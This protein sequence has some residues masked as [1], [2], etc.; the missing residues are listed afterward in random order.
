[1]MIAYLRGGLSDSEKLK[2]EEQMKDDPL[3]VE[4]M[5]ELDMYL[6]SG[7]SETDAI[8]RRNKLKKNFSSSRQNNIFENKPFIYSAAASLVILVVGLFAIYQ[9][10]KSGEKELYS[11]YYQPYEDII[12]TRGNTEDEV[13]KA[14]RYYNNKEYAQAEAILSNISKVNKER[15]IESFYLAQSQLAQGKYDLAINTLESFSKDDSSLLRTHARWYIALAHLKLGRK[16]EAMKYLNM[17]MME[18]E[19]YNRKK[20]I[21]LLQKLKE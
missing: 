20:A 6:K 17:Q 10:I 4:S 16:D 12:T 9:I 3:L 19:S 14:M 13:A 2:I 18:E 21:E 8:D 15:T 1:M 11:E 5:A 7:G